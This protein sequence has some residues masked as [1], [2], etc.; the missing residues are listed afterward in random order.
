MATTTVDR[1]EQQKA[2]LDEWL[3][4]RQE[5]NRAE[6]RAAAL[7]GARAALMEEDIAEQP[8][9]HDAIWRSMI[10]EF[11]AAGR[12]AKGS[13]EHAFTDA[14]FLATD[15]YP[16]LRASFES[17][18]ITAAHM[19]EILHAAAPVREAVD[20]GS[21]TPDT[22]GLYETAAVVFAESE[23]PSRTRAHVREIAAALAGSTI[24]DR[25]MRARDEREVRMRS[26]GDGL[27]LLQVVLPEHFAVAIMDRLTQLAR[28]QKSHP[29]DRDPVLPVDDDALDAEAADRR[30]F[31]DDEQPRSCAGDDVIFGD[32]DTFTRDPFDDAPFEDDLFDDD[33]F[34]DDPAAYWAFV[35]RMIAAGPQPIRI[36]ADERS[37]DQIRA[38]LLADLLLGADPT[39]A[40]GNGLQ[41][42]KATIQVT[43]GAA[44]L[45][46]ADDQT[47]QLDG[48]GELHP[49]V[50]RVLAG[51]SAGWT[52]L[53]LDPTGM[54]TETDSYT[55][56]AGMRRFL[57]A[58]DQHCRFPGC[59]MPTHRTEIDHN[60]DHALGGRTSTDNLAHLCKTHHA[61]K[62]PDISARHRWTALQLPN[63]DV[64]WTSPSGQIYAD[65]VPRRVMFVPSDTLRSKHAW[66]TDSAA[67][68]G[69]DA[70]F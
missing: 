6:A 37:I 7:L 32:E 61:L 24:N 4:V 54:V 57:R 13:A 51:M 15:G 22:L 49:D 43:I 9:S 38:D 30:H 11:S 63:S 46:D 66:Q 34:D 31:I 40:Q 23:S 69:S 70:P 27:A 28:H 16:A 48:H 50:A 56:T 62:H 20:D 21:V 12:I 44:T 68:P 33:P 35:D 59:R 60:H 36:P 55:P 58:R 39:A 67:P 47:A 19:R 1:L 8:L 17:G 14:Q 3:T 52:R 25:H 65:A 29:E 53:F 5:I 18:D 26:L 10:A 41:N 45:V 64:R 2:L 42:I